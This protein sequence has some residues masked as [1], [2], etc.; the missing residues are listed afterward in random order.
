MLTV[1]R[2]VHIGSPSRLSYRDL[3]LV[4]QREGAGEGTVP[5]ADLAVL[6]CDFAAT[7]LTLPLLAALSEAGVAVVVCGARHLPV[8]ILLPPAGAS[9]HTRILREQVAASEP[10]KKRIWQTIVVEKIRA[11]AAALEALRGADAGLRLMCRRVGS[12]DPQNI[13][14]RAARTYFPALFGAGFVRDPERPGVNAALNY[15]Y[16]VVRAAVARAVVGAGLHPALGVHHRNQY[17]AFALADD[18]MEPLRPLV[19]AMVARMAG[20]GAIP[21]E[22]PTL[23]R[24]ELLKVL[25]AQVEWDGVRCPLFTALERYGASLRVCICGEERKLRCPAA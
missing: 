19:D 20:K 11:Q 23:L 24:T 22:L 3:H 4:V 12:G 6:V 7:T 9:L 2:V 8:G 13:E 16:A 14:G 1:G 21:D 10:R 15:G 25:T 17:D 5:V 18:A